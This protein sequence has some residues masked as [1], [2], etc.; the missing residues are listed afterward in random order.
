VDKAFSAFF[1]RCKSGGKAG[2]PRFKSYGRY[3]SMTCPDDNKYVTKCGR[4]KWH[5]VGEIDMKL[6]RPI[7]GRI[8]TCT[9][10]REGSKW[11]VVFS[12]DNVEPKVL[13]PCDTSVGID[14][15]IT[16]FATLSDDTTIANPRF[17]RKSQKQISTAQRSVAR[18]KKGSNRRRKAVTRLKDAHARLSN[19][20]RDFHHKT[21]RK[22]V[23]E[24]GRIAVEK[25]NI[26]NMVKNRHLARS[27]SDAGWSQFIEILHAKAEEAGR[28]FVAVNPNG[29]SQT[30][31][32]GES[33][34][35]TLSDRWHECVCG[36]SCGRD[37]MSARVILQRANFN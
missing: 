9:V 8:K 13:P 20:R 37:V 21:A 34:P 27:I 26:R 30:C 16:D 14:V 7:E 36:E 25:L 28:G 17:G 5:G 1:R 18:K 11:Y 6:H 2:Y 33:V 32:C 24:F 31:V 4:L 35:K 23:N 12:C 22:I 19:R 10:K 3:D 15:G 29:T